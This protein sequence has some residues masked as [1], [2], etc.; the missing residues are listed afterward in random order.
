MNATEQAE[1]LGLKPHDPPSRPWSPLVK[2]A[3]GRDSK[4][5]WEEYGNEY[6]LV[7]RRAAY[8]MIT[9]LDQS[10]RRDWREF[11]RIKNELYGDEAEAVELYPAE[12]RVQDPS[13][14]FFLWR[15]RGRARIGVYTLVSH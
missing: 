7:I 3:E 1:C 2:T 10:A 11:Q 8:L 13:N 12:S 14:A 15:I 6:Y 9:N 4:G 5:R